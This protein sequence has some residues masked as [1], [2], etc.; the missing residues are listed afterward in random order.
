MWL[1]DVL[2]TFPMLCLAQGVW[3]CLTATARREGVMALYKGFLPNFIKVV[4]TIAIMFTV[5]DALKGMWAER[6]A[7]GAN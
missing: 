1:D 2:T 7:R 5:N 3:D 6:S 4:P